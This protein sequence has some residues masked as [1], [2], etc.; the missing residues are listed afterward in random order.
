MLNRSIVFEKKTVGP[1]HYI[2]F[3]LESQLKRLISS[4]DCNVHELHILI[5][6][7]GLPLY[8][9]SPG[10]GIPILVSIVNVPELQKKVFAIGLYYGFQKLKETD[11]FLTS[12]VL[13]S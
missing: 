3:G 6:I 8:K 10:Q 2:H 4:F 12:F 11:N 1:E 13:K 7:D 5:N 9:S